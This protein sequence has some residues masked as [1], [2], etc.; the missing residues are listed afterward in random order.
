MVN[1]DGNGALN[2]AAYHGYVNVASLLLSNGAT[3]DVEDKVH[4]HVHVHAHV[5]MRLS[6]AQQRAS[7]APPHTTYTPP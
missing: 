2:C 6:E 5:A 1:C 7:S 3:V 4:V